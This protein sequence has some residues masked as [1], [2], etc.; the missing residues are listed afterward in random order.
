MYGQIM[1]K[2]LTFAVLSSEERSS[3]FEPTL[4]SMVRFCKAFPP[5]VEDV[6]SLLLQYGRVVASEACLA[7]ALAGNLKLSKTIEMFSC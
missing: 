7:S 1:I 2:I 4:G 5:L 6:T 3:L